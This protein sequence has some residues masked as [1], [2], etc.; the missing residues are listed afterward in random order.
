[1]IEYCEEFIHLDM[2]NEV[3]RKAVSDC[4]GIANSYQVKEET[5][6]K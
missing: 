5:K 1:M 6:Q 2:P 4:K 3:Y